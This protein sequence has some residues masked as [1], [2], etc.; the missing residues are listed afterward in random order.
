MKAVF[1]PSLPKGKCQAPP[2]KSMAHRAL[3]AAAFAEGESTIAPPS[4]SED[5]K[6]TLSCLEALGAKFEI[7]QNAVHVWGISFPAPTGKDLFCGESGSTL[8]FLLPIC[9]LAG[10][11]ITLRGAE[12]LLERPLSVYENLC[13]EKGFFFE[14]KDGAITVEG[15]L[16]AGTYRIPA[17][18]SSQ[19][20]T[21]MLFA[22]SLLEGE[23][24][25]E[26]IGKAESASYLDLTLSAMES[27]GVKIQK[28]ENGFVI[29]ANCRYSPR[30]YTVE[31]DASNAA[32]LDALALVG[33]EV[34]VSGL[35]ERSLQGDRI[36]KEHFRAIR[37]GFAEIDL[38][39]CPDLGPI[40]FALAAAH[41]GAKF[42]G[43]ARLALKESDR[44]AA[45]A[46]ELAKCGVSLTIKENEI[47][48]PSGLTA[49]KEPICGH[50]DHRIVMAM[51]T[52]LIRLGG[53]ILGAEAVKK[54][55]P[56]Y[57][58]VLRDLKTQ[59]ILNETE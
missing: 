48:V 16:S 35:N 34:S 17:N 38:S 20:I 33:G 10:K 41:H 25:I 5:I 49:P 52:L 7:R 3:I 12:R 21:G 39:D 15:R 13:R 9:L 28:Q 27:F 37:E 2:S 8:R 4:F 56:E 18:I 59:V 51:S 19:F 42:S 11:R 31:G 58:N 47:L 50:N 24:R 44:G 29:P 46:E 36:Y 40:L 45:M 22:L 55:F 32:F 26:L 23:S 1:T 54:S 30:N 6:A 57:F 53:E 43:T 14:K